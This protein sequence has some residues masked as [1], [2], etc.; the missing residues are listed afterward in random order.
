[1]LNSSASLWLGITFVL[2]GAINVWLILQSSARLRDAK[3]G[4]RLIVAHRIGGYVFI[5]L[6]CVMGYFMVARL[7][8][9]AG[10]APPGTIIHLTL[11]MVLSPL[12]FVKVLI[13]RYY[14]SHYSLLMPI[15]L[16]I[17]V[18]SFVLIGITAGPTLAHRARM[19]TVSLA[20]ID[21]P[22]EAVDINMAAATMEKRCSKCHT[23]DRIAGARKDAPGWLATVNRMKALPDSG[24]S[25]E[26]ARTIVSYLASEMAPKGSVD[27]A[28]L[29][30]ARAVVDQRCGRCHS[31]DRVYKTAE[32][33]EE[34]RGTVTRMVG[35]AEGSGNAFQPGE[36]EQI[37]AYL[38][39]MQTP[40]AVSQRGAQV[41]AAASAGRSMVTQQVRAASDQGAPNSR[42]DAGMIG[43]IA[44]V[45]LSVVA[46][47][48]RRPA[49]ARASARSEGAAG[50]V[51][52]PVGAVP[53]RIPSPGGPLILRLASITQ[54][55]SGAKTLRFIVA[56][57][58][59][60]NA[61]PGQFLTFWF[62]FDGRK[63]ARS[64]SICSSPARSGYVEITTKRVSQGCVSV[65]LND[66]A[67]IG[68]TV[69]ANGPFGRFCFDESKH[70]NVV[71][72]AAGSG[73]TPMMAMLRYMDDICLE[74]TVTL[75]YSV[76][77][78]NDIIFQGELEE[79]RTRLK[80]FQYHVLLS[81]PHAE[82]S[83]PRGHVSREF[84]E[85][86]VRGIAQADYFLCGPPAFMEASR[87]ILT[88]L[89]VKPERITQE[90]FGSRVPKSSQPE[91]GATEPI[92]MAEFIRSGK[93]CIVRSGQTLLDAAEQHG[94]SIPSSC[95]QGQC[96][97]CKT[98]LLGG[99]VRM[100]AE[101]GLD[102]DSREQGFVLTC[103]GYPDSDA[104]R[105]DA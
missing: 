10:G 18:L 12:L 89:G 15:G 35:Y 56:D 74:T 7:G 66:R 48:I 20:A 91:S 79:L 33:P 68:M 3:A 27:A 87:G 80:N 31:L 71:L 38:S 51:E 101:E 5:A 44:F 53:A 76:R 25:E 103:V 8:D 13:A 95:R 65:F 90:S 34:W 21:L 30:V 42:S 49:R 40:E 28:S 63:V 22:P 88:G 24:I 77:T 69:E 16:M 41:T 6:F 97:T 26:D 1:M 73:I 50:T 70:H 104:V 17:F 11:A 96:G 64:Y 14:K 45:C 36:D 98:K 9:V 102:P 84:V 58:Q 23:L 67:S 4:A 83:G 29:E 55:A 92:A 105:L 81:Q 94:V 86:T 100:D 93:T 57:G 99:T 46:L 43:F 32:T 62:L 78:I 61:R 47:I 54:Q 19:Q 52:V 72:L 75:L 85:K 39:R 59:K 2:V 82:W 37:I 60:L